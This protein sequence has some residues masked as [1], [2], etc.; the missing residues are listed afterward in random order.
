[1]TIM[2]NL[3]TDRGTDKC[4][5]FCWLKVTVDPRWLCWLLRNLGLI[6]TTS[7][8][9]LILKSQI[10]LK[11]LSRHTQHIYCSTTSNHLSHTWE[12]CLLA[13]IVTWLQLARPIAVWL[14][15]TV[16]DVF[17]NHFKKLRWNPY[18]IK[19]TIL[20]CVV[21][22]QSAVLCKYQLYLI[23]KFSVTSKEYTVCA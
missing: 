13:L 12:T 2:G 7:G 10:G 22:W 16:L 1:M 5:E 9:L 4:K 15:R 18:N 8:N 3:G 17:V 23:P 20:N 21:Q 11:R 6:G 19:I 14:L